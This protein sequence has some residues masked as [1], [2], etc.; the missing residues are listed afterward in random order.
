ME[1]QLIC[2]KIFYFFMGFISH[3]VAIVAF[4]ISVVYRFVVHSVLLKFYVNK[5]RLIE[6]GITTIMAGETKGPVNVLYVLKCKGAPPNVD[7]IVDKLNQAVNYET[8]VIS[9]GES[10]T[11]YRPFEK[12]RYVI[13]PKFG[14]FCWKIDHN[15]RAANHVVLD[16]VQ[17]N[18]DQMIQDRSEKLLDT[19]YGGDQ[20]QWDVHILSREESM[21]YAIVWSVHHTYADANIFTQVIRYILADSPFPMKVEPLEWNRK[22]PSSYR[23]IKSYVETLLLCTLGSGFCAAVY[24]Q[25]LGQTHVKEVRAKTFE[26]L[27]LSPIIFVDFRTP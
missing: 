4:L 16:K 22:S 14:V 7:A 21:E 19:F 20:P 5:Y 13:V 11:Y 6:A 10:E 8:K 23:K 24:G 1:F 25:C 12:L 26:G 18:L 15:F 17:E 3:L 27:K 2:N 9:G